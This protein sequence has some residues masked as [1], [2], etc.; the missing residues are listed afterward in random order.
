VVESGA[1]VED[2]DADEAAVF[3]LEHDEPLGAGRSAG[4]DG[5]AARCER[6]RL[7]QEAQTN[8]MKQT[9]PGASA[10]VRLQLMLAWVCVDVEDDGAVRG[11]EPGNAGSGLTGMRQRISVFGGELDFGARHPRGWRVAARLYLDPAAAS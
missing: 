7:V 1:G 9:G 11:P 3:P 4:L 6:V 5:G 2:L 10:A 8:T